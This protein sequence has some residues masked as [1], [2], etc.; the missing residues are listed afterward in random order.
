LDAATV[1]FSE[2]TSGMSSLLKFHTSLEKY[3]YRS[4][5][6]SYTCLERHTSL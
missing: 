6:E 5:E 4:W 2:M 3:H 1:V